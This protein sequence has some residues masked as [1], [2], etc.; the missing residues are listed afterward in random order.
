VGAVTKDLHERDRQ[1]TTD[2]PGLH[3]STG[4][5]ALLRDYTKLRRNAYD[6]GDYDALVMAI[7][8]EAAIEAARLTEKQREVL[9]LVYIEGLTQEEAAGE[10]GIGQ[11]TVSER[12]TASAV[13]IANVYADWREELAMDGEY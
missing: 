4:V 2:Y 6:K 12:I 10:A 5:K 13:K 1:Y 8:L 3:T 9:R 11:N 7:D